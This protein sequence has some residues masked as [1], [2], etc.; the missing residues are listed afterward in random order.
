MPRSYPMQ[1][2]FNTGELS[3]R[4]V[5]RTD[6]S[7]YAAGALE[8]KNLIVQAQGGIKHRPGTR[9]V[10]EVKN[11]ANATR[12]VAFVFS[13]VQAYILEF[14]NNL[15]RFYKDEGVIL[16]GGN[17]LE[18]GTTYTT[19]EIPDLQFTQSADILFIAHPDHPVA[20]LTRTSD[21]VWTLSDMEFIDG[22]YLPQ[23]TT[24]TTLAP[25]GF[26]PTTVVTA[27]SIVGI[28]GGVGFR[29]SDVGRHMRM[30]TDGAAG[31]VSDV[32]WGV[33]TIF[34]DTTHVT[35]E[36]VE[37]FNGGSTP[38]TDWRLGA[39]G[40]AADLGFPRVL[41]FH[42]QRLWLGANPGGPQTVYGS[43]ISLFGTFSPTDFSDPAGLVVDDS[44][45]NYTIAAD[46]VNAIHWMN[47]I[48]ALLMGTSGGLWPVQATTAL[49]AI[50][51]TNI[52]IN[53]SS[54]NGGAA[55]QPA[56]AEDVAIYVS[57]TKRK[58]WS[59]GFDALKDAFGSQELTLL[60]DHITESG[61]DVLAYAGEPHSVIWAVRGDG[62]LVGLTHVPSQDVFAWHRH[63][64]GGVFG[65]GD[66]VVESIAVIPAPS[67]DPSSTG[68]TNIDHDQV[69]LIVKRTI[70]G[71]TV[72]YVE[73]MED[74]FADTDVLEDAFYVDSGLTYNDV[75]TATITGLDHLE[76]ETVQVVV[77]GAA[78]PDRTVSGGSITLNSTYTKVHVGLY[79][80]AQGET[81]NLEPVVS[82]LRATGSAQGRL[83]RIP[84]LILRFDRTLGGEVCA[85]EDGATFD[86]I[87]FRAVGDPMDAP[88]PLFTG[89]KLMALECGW[90][91]EARVKFR[92]PQ[93]LPWNL[94]ALIPVVELA[95]R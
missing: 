10:L 84:R 14:S 54:V 79:S 51:P 26:T 77:E 25:D 34:T 68:R 75:A 40:T 8:I 23:N 93:P 12:L 91:R 86:P 32:G 7:K 9:F 48:R 81:L 57:N 70:D 15:I 73:F 62:V 27:S 78:H 16:S 80:T 41:T 89:D 82:G 30:R 47:P 1:N 60:A 43:M 92:Q 38:N 35:V 29:A 71:V 69:W 83:K 37:N 2:S 13:T 20:E 67:G 5:G 45:M 64:L 24:E 17:P 87:F 39:F 4:L 49:E 61:V 63:T 52:Q 94:I 21:T 3:P 28:N 44:G 53:R 11:S 46:Q 72:R 65:S 18:V 74:D 76:G 36:M 42:E 85:N 33:I 56:N 55:V 95:D 66:A 22:P 88:P 59:A 6:L 58:I 50:T 90:S 31:S 19:A